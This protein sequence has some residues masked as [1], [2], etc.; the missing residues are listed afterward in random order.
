MPITN[1]RNNFFQNDYSELPPNQKRKKIQSK[2]DQLNS[3]ISQA[4]NVK[5][6]LI[7][8]RQAYEE[9]E[10]FGDP[11]TIESQL[12]ENEAT[13]DRLQSELTKHLVLLDE[14]DVN[15]TD[16]NNT[17][18]ETESNKSPSINNSNHHRT[19][20]GPESEMSRTNSDN[21]LRPDSNNREATK[22]SATNRT[23]NSFNDSISDNISNNAAS[24]AP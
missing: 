1:Q 12:R 14:M 13:L 8:M 17:S 7:I 4:H 2:I 3:Q 15:K 19:S 11:K 24:T 20:I 6:G 21:S 18:L 10:A 5:D 9:N 22:S 16:K 23:S